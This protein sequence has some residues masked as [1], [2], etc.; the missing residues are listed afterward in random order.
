[1]AKPG[2]RFMSGLRMADPEAWKRDVLRAKRLTPSIK[3]AAIHLGVSEQTF[4]R[5]LKEIERSEGWQR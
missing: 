2:N 1:M 3:A 5:W 4:G